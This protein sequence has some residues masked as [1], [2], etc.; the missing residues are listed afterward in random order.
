MSSQLGLFKRLR[1]ATKLLGQVS[2]DEQRILS[3]IIPG[4]YK[5]SPHRGVNGMLTA[6]SRS[7]WVRA[8][9][10]KIAESIGSTSWGLFA[11][12]GSGGKFIKH[13][14]LQA[15]GISRKDFALGNLDLDGGQELVPI[16]DH[17]FLRLLN[18]A[19][20]LFP[21]SVGRAQTS[22]SLELTG[23]AFWILDPEWQGGRAVP[24]RFWLIPA[25]WVRGMPSQEEPYWQ[26][27]TPNWQGKL[28]VPAVFRFV[29]PDPVNPYG[30]G[31]AHLRAFGDEID[32]DEYAAQYTKNWFLNS[33]RP[34]LLITS[35]DLD[36]SDTARMETSWMQQVGSFMRAHKPMFLSKKV[37]VQILSSKF[38][39]ME[40]R[41]LRAW[42][43]DII[44]H[45]IGMPPEILGIIE[46]SNRATIEAADYLMAK[47]VL[48]PR[49][50][51][52]RTF[53]QYNLLPIY[54]DRLILGYESPVEEDAAYQL[55]VMKANPAAFTI[56]EWKQ[57]AGKPWDEKDEVYLLPFNVK[58]V[59]SLEP[60]VDPLAAGVRYQQRTPFL[61]SG[62]GSEPSCGCTE[63]IHSHGALPRSTEPIL[64]KGVG[65][66]QAVTAAMNYTEEMR[67]E[68]IR[69]F[70]AL[71]NEVDLTELAAAFDSGNVNRVLAL[72][73]EAD[74]A[75]SLEG[76]RQILK[77][78][79]V[80]AG[81]AAAAELSTFL[82]ETIAFSLI[83]PNAVEFLETY[84][85][86]MVTNITPETMEAIRAALAEA[87]E[88]GLTPAEAAKRIRD[89]IGL[90]A[91]ME[92]QRAKL[93]AD[94]LDAGATQSEVDA[95]IADWTEAKI[96]WRANNIAQNELAT[97]SNQGQEMLWDQAAQ[98]GYIDPKK[99]TREWLT[100]GSDKVCPLCAPMNGALTRIGEPWQTQVGP[101]MTPNEIH[102]R[103]QC[104]EILNPG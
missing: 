99:A 41:P 73:S 27:S 13:N 71:R 2:E 54:D 43:R 28:P 45:G 5:T 24:E 47:Y 64:G 6:Y 21:G 58:V 95:F 22:I 69:A 82:G 61:A 50:E 100:T 31:S 86:A 11:V 46:N 23:E 17:P 92:R 15:K 25:T 74:I 60:T 76:S 103:C 93:I 97:A 56:A 85:G 87:Y 84:G 63:G 62:D 34:D 19:N 10:G 4:G 29:T 40:M 18:T 59:S 96:K 26:I 67:K 20:P 68:I 80:S 48:T 39:D 72:I 66:D 81:E 42:E 8:V 70:M 35:N 101:V 32:T 51:L 75:D 12:K 33:A 83:N 16:T 55:E 104:T 14:R 88:L 36:P 38:S 65:G 53:L 102:V 7:P 98:E 1:L 94:M 90:T 9:V 79:L 77:E 49:L 89:S 37:D 78:A 57:Q 3:K 30:R 44:L 91:D 52:Q